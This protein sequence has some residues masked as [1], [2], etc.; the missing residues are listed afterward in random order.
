MRTLSVILVQIF[1]L[2]GRN[3]NNI[4]SNDELSGFTKLQPSLS[5]KLMM[6]E[7]ILLLLVD[8]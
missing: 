4:E 1:L 8:I 6:L 7:S 3:D 5:L 2:F